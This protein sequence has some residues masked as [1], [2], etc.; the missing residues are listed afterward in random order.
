MT[1]V[2]HSVRA[3]EPHEY[4]PLLACIEAS[5][6]ERTTE[7]KREQFVAGFDPSR[8]LAAFDGPS[9]VGTSVA[10]GVELTLPGP[11]QVQALALAD[12]TV[13]PTHR[14]R[15][16]LT[17]LMRR[18]LDAAH[19][20]GD[21]AVV[22]EASEAGIYSRFGYGPATN[23]SKYAIDRSRAALRERTALSEGGNV[24][25]LEPR[26]A[27]EAF[28]V[29]FDEARRQ[30]VGELSRAAWWWEEL[31]APPPESGAPV[32]FLAAYEERGSI[33]GYAVYDVLPTA[34]GRREVVLDECCTTSDAAY[35]GLF[36][37]LL[38]I[39]L[40]DGLRTGPRPL[41]EPLRDMLVD[42]RALKT[43][44]TRDGAWL[45][46]VDAPGALRSRRYVGAG[47]VIVELVDSFCP[48]N[49]GR[50]EL[51]VAPD[52]TARVERATAE[53]DLTCDA[54]AL[55]AVYL[56]GSRTTGLRRAG[57]IEEHVAGACERFDALLYCD[58]LPFC[59]TL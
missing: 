49:A 37:F 5:F 25:L 22:L 41:D 28:P 18:T 12:V 27:T 34:G 56:G 53:P 57:R 8:T 16:I 11:V 2:L 44:E 36:A 46:L 23:S 20:R 47:R 26:D 19:E 21:L 40:T 42:S 30:R 31:I 55:A 14:R 35:A 38:A 50:L 58:P 10:Y 45:R 15:G 33:D 48:W 1:N 59:M 43:L 3:P 51:E 6:A 4:D 17:A 52:G 24:L 39:D 32:R 7:L 29:V 54:S 9:L 13:L